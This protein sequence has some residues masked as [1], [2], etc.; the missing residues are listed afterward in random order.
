MN[1]KE[2]LRTPTTTSSPSGKSESNRARKLRHALLY[3]VCG[4][5][6]V[7]PLAVH[8]MSPFAVSPLASTS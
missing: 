8:Q 2:P 4:D 1:M 5:E 3:L 6:D 7:Y